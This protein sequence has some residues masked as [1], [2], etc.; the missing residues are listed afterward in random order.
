MNLK[1]YLKYFEYFSSNTNSYYKQ[2]DIIFNSKEADTVS[3]KQLKHL[4]YQSVT[5]EKCYTSK[6]HR[7]LSEL[8]SKID[9]KYDFNLRPFIDEWYHSVAFDY[10]NDELYDWEF[11]LYGRKIEYIESIVKRKHETKDYVNDYILQETCQTSILGR[12]LE[13]GTKVKR[14][15]FTNWYNFDTIHSKKILKINTSSNTWTI[16]CKNISEKLITLEYLGRLWPDL[17][18]ILDDFCWSQREGINSLLKLVVNGDGTA[19]QWKLLFSK[20]MFTNIHFDLFLE[21][22]FKS[23]K[24]FLD[25]LKEK[26]SLYSDDERFN[27]LINNHSLELK[28]DKVSILEKEESK[29]HQSLSYEFPDIISLKSNLLEDSDLD[30][31]N[32]VDM[33]KSSL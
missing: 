16:F 23:S 3:T 7:L 11:I 25:A 18:L 6:I 14:H 26:Y 29:S 9:F 20:I 2:Y 17:I 24:P 32:Q 8:L 21:S 13:E 5:E 4:I 27:A 10:Y 19:K 12:T 33:D 28:I 30:K 22:N 1:E 15:T 31:K